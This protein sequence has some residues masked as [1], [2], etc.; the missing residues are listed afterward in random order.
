MAIEPVVTPGL[1]AEDHVLVDWLELVAFFNEFRTA[2]LDELDAAIEEQFET[3]DDDGSDDDTDDLGDDDAGNIARI[4]A[5]KE[6]V[7]ERIENEVD[8]RL[9]DCESAYPFVLGEDAEELVL[10]EDWQDDRFTPY[11]TCLITT[12]LTKNS[13]FDFEV[14]EELIQRLRNRVFQV[15]STLAM[16]GLAKG[17]ASSIGWPRVDKADIITTLKRAEARGA[18]F[19]TRE[20]PGAYTPPKEKDG[21]VDVISWQIDIRTPPILFFFAQVASG[22]NWPG[23]PVE[24]HA[25]LFQ[26]HYFDYTHRGNVSYATLLPFRVADE[27]Q[28]NNEHMMHGALL[29]RTRLP[30]H[31][32][33]GQ[34]LA[35][36]GVEMDESENMPQV[37]A[38]LNDFRATA[39]A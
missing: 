20:T 8:F 24:S 27:G 38:W 14:A 30:K 32:I 4:D 36:D 16:A 11:L 9:K 22:H 19:H 21:G 18:G 35:R 28:W 31:A 23:K 2:R 29:D 33:M 6:R 5:A 3:V 12:H 34:A 25:K 13:L 10:V 37:L 15:L 26:M 1:N 7:R 39:L 17:S